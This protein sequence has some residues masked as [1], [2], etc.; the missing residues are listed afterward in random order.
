MTYTPK[1]LALWTL[2]GSYMGEHWN[3]YYVFLTQHRDSDSVT[4]S[5][6]ICGL[7]AVGG[8]SETVLTVTEGHWAVGWV[9]WIAIHK[10]DD[11]A[12]EIADKLAGDL[13]DY[14]VLNEDH[15]SGLEYDEACEYWESMSIRDRAEYCVRAGQSIFAARRNWFDDPDGRMQEM[16][17]GV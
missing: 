7:R 5:N 4:V 16:L 11:K 6:Y 9:D 12:L 3:D 13:I 15:W 14:P 17:N 8:A 2:P 1:H 10:S